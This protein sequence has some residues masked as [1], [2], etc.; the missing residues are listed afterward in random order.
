VLRIAVVALSA[1]FLTPAAYAANETA[2]GQAQPS[3]YSPSKPAIKPTAKTLLQAL[4]KAESKSD[5]KRLER[6]IK[7]LWSQSGS[8]SADLL[9]ERGE[10]AFDDGDVD[11]ARS[12]LDKL[13]SVAPRFAEGWHQRAAVATEMEEYQDAMV[14]LRHVLA[15][16]PNHFGALAE[17][18]QILEEFGDKPHA[19][20]AYRRAL[21]LNPYLEGVEERIS[22]LSRDVEGRGI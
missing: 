16:E 9:L 4:A 12:I 14:S 8:P 22:E 17:L 13:T 20:D 21:A 18:G 2:S 11:T 7:E 19:L 5:A 10:T 6:Q 3:A 15:I 1:L